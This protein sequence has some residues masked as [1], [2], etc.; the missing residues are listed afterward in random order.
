MP[1][2]LLWL[3]HVL[4]IVSAYFYDNLL[5]YYTSLC[6]IGELMAVFSSIVTL[7]CYCRPQCC[8]ICTTWHKL[9]LPCLPWVITVF[10]WAIT[11]IHS[12]IFCHV[13]L[14]YHSPQMTHC[15][16]IS[17]RYPG[18]MI[19]N[20]TFFFINSFFYLFCKY[21]LIYCLFSGASNGRIQHCNSSLET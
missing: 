18:R 17:Q 20:N 8:S 6:Y 14:W 9:A 19:Q 15:S 5:W 3:C 2:F 12:L 4:C 13:A 16:F 10:S 11:G 1:L 21:L 7:Y